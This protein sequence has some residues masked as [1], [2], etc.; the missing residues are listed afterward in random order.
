[1]ERILIGDNSQCSNTS[2]FRNDPCLLE[3][4]RPINGKCVNFDSNLSSRPSDNYVEPCIIDPGVSI[5]HQVESSSESICCYAINVGA[6]VG[7]I[8]GGIVGLIILGIV[9]FFV[10]YRYCSASPKPDEPSAASA[11]QTRP[12]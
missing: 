7:G 11:D 8:I 4:L 12:R 5:F 1:M 2:K 10:Y 9:A 3:S 6:I